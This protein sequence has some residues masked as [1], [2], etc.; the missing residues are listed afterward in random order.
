MCGRFNFTEGAMGFYSEWCHIANLN[1]PF[2]DPKFDG[3]CGRRRNHL[4]SLSMVCSASKNDR[5][6]ITEDDMR[7]SAEL[8][9]EVENKMGM[10][11]RGIGK[12]EISSLISDA[13][14][15]IENS[16]SIEIPFWKFARHFE[17]NMDKITMDRVLTTLEASK[18]IQLVT[19]PGLGTTIQ[20]IK[21]RSKNEQT[22]DQSFDV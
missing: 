13:I 14:V 20:I 12:S 22:N 1:P 21:D 4:L 9:S 6:I 16:D 19:K 3:Y 10:T 5:M 2:R 8:L 15:F 18:Y 11:F 7:R 17:G